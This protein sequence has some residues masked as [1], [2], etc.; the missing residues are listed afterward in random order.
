MRASPR[1]EGPRLKP[2]V[3]E[4]H[5]FIFGKN[6]PIVARF[7]VPYG[8]GALSGEGWVVEIPGRSGP[9]VVLRPI[10]ADSSSL[11]VLSPLEL[12][13]LWDHLSESDRHEAAEAKA[14]LRRSGALDDVLDQMEDWSIV[15]GPNGVEI[16]RNNNPVPDAIPIALPGAVWGWGEGWV[17]GWVVPWE[18]RNWILLPKDPG[19][20]TEARVVR[21]AERERLL[22][23][24]LTLAQSLDPRERN[25]RKLANRALEQLM[26]TGLL[27]PHKSA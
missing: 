4:H 19:E 6:C 12:R 3:H 26:A 21:Q 18:G 17:D 8:E 9:S 25:T 10:A 27:S 7:A 24:L 14:I 23:H 16:R 13:E 5:L 20:G 11:K 15:R 2:E 1:Q 22:A